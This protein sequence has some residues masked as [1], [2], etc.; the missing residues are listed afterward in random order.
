MFETWF[1]KEADVPEPAPAEEP[2]RVYKYEDF[3]DPTPELSLPQNASL[4]D[5]VAALE[6]KVANLQ[7]DLKAS[8]ASLRS[9][10]QFV[11]DWFRKQAA[12]IYASLR[13]KM[14]AELKKEVVVTDVLREHISAAVES[15]FQREAQ[16]LFNAVCKSVLSRIQPN[17]LLRR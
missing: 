7:T 10:E 12:E 14:M 4:P 2:R 9:S 16:E 5:K 11:D 17:A 1:K 3:C 13:D 8:T 6:L 15:V